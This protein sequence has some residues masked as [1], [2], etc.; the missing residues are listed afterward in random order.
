ML[1]FIVPTNRKPKMNDARALLRW[2]SKK[3]GIPDRIFIVNSESNEVFVFLSSEV[4]YSSI[5]DIQ[6]ITRLD[7]E[8]VFIRSFDFNLIGDIK[9]NRIFKGFRPRA[10]NRSRLIGKSIVRDDIIVY[11][12]KYSV[13]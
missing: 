2:A 13:R 12:E 3:I 10:G 4:A 7:G 1:T 9:I 8:V 5:P 11:D 6:E